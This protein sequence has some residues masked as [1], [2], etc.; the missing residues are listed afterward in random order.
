MKTPL[1]PSKPMQVFGVMGPDLKAYTFNEEPPMDWAY[2]EEGRV[3]VNLANH[4]F[5]RG[6]DG[7]EL[8]PREGV[9]PQKAWDHLMALLRSWEP[10]HEHKTAWFAKL[11]SE[12]FSE[13]RKKDDAAT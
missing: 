8:I 10:K 13:W 6:G 1:K 9:D 2:S 12:W 5:F 11:A 7:I 3:W 4:V